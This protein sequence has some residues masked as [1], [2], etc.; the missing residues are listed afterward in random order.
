[1]M[2]RLCL[3]LVMKM[4][5]VGDGDGYAV[6]TFYWMVGLLVDCWLIYIYCVEMKEL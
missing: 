2:N 5:V 4:N 6:V 1:M 3:G